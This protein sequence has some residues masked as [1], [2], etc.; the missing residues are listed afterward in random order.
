MCMRELVLVEAH[1][2]FVITIV[3][4]K[5]KVKY[6]SKKTTKNSLIISPKQQKYAILYPCKNL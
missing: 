5:K 3:V 2:A 1:P 4:P 6:K